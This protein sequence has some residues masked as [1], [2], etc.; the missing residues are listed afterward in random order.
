[1]A[2]RNSPSSILLIRCRSQSGVDAARRRALGFAIG[3]LLA[4]PLAAS[5]D[6]ALE[7]YTS[8]SAFVERVVGVRVVDFDDVDTLADPDAFTAFASDRYLASHGISIAGTAGQ[9]ASRGFGYPADYVAVSSPNVYAPGPPAAFGAPPGSGGRDTDVT[10]RVERS[11][12]AVSGFGVWFIDA[13]FPGVGASSFTIYDTVGDE[14]GTTGTVSGPNASQL[15]VGVVAVDTGSQQPTP[16]I[17]RVHIVN[18]SGWPDV[19]ANEGVVLDDLTFPAPVPVP[20]PDA[21]PL[22][23]AAALWLRARRGSMLRSNARA[24]V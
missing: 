22:A 17:A 6:V 12:A 11:A 3:V 9:Y 23:A 2:I 16:A 15:F 1:V 8:A 5:A 4:S 13:D 18:G 10:F 21:S 20:E 14:L 7:L 19:D 24:S